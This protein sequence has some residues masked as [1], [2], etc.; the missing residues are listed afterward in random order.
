VTHWQDYS[1]ETRAALATLS[2][3]S[4]YFPGC[5]TPIV[6]L[7]GDR[8]IVNV[9]IVRIR[10]SEPGRPGYVAGLSE[11]DMQSFDN[12]LLLCVPHRRIVDQDR[13]SHPIDLLE[14]WRE[15]GKGDRQRP[16]SA[17]RNVTDHSIEKLL[18]TAFTAAREQ[19]AQALTRFERVDSNSAQ[20]LRRLVGGL[21]AQRTDGARHDSA[22]L[23][24]EAI[25]RLAALADRLRT[26]AEDI[27]ALERTVRA[28]EDTSARLT[29]AAETLSRLEDRTAGAEPAPKRTNIG[30]T[31]DR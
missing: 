25:D 11:T 7:V 27:N 14:T 26:A 12:L 29:Q 8:P 13:E 6:I 23:L 19:I 4:C 30:W 22:A 21:S 24:A 15:A 10:E 9:E 18:A 31:T 28:I 2:Q 5:S 16:L 20:L 1:A 17:V 3:G